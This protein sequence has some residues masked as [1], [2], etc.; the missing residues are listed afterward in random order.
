MAI[1]AFETNEEI[2]VARGL[3]ARA[4][5]M[6]GREEPLPCAHKACAERNGNMDKMIEKLETSI[7]NGAE[8]IVVGGGIAG[9]AA[10]VAARAAVR[11][12]CCWKRARCWVDW[13]PTASSTGTSR[14]ATGHGEQLMTGSQRNCSG[15]PSAMETTRFPG[16]GRMRPAGGSQ[17]DQP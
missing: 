8:V 7:E 16:S 17:P 10:A 14:F 15:C 1:W 13:L 2:M 12:S 9:V 3:H 11:T 5:R 6:S 4:G